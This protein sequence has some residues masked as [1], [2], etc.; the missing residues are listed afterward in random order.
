METEVGLQVSYQLFYSSLSFLQLLLL[1][2]WLQILFPHPDLLLLE[3]LVSMLTVLLSMGARLFSF[4]NLHLNMS[5]VKTLP[6]C[7]DTQWRGY[8]LPQNIGVQILRYPTTLL[9][10]SAVQLPSSPS[11]FSSL[12]IH[13][14]ILPTTSTS[15]LGLC[16]LP[17]ELFTC[18]PL[19]LRSVPHIVSSM[20]PRLALSPERHKTKWFYLTLL[21][22]KYPTITHSIRWAWR[23]TTTPKIN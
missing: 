4:G 11:S 9:S 19:A 23:T 7:A 2:G 15:Q 14:P 13:I 22:R 16:H 20:H 12:Q 3:H 18:P 10:P 1:H 5:Q 21:Y 17:P 8:F 6:S